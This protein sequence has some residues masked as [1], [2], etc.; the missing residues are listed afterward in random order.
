MIEA[1]VSG[2]P[3]LALSN[4]AVP[5]VLE[6]FPELICSTPEE[7]AEKLMRQDFPDPKEMRSYVLGNFTRDRMARNYLNIYYELIKA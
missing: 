1:M 2:T 6:R 4:G 5:E 3:V 7:M